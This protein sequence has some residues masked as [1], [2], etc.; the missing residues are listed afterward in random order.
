MNFPEA[1]CRSA[2]IW[3]AAERDTGT[4]YSADSF[5]VSF[6]RYAFRQHSL[7]SAPVQPASSGNS[8]D[9]P[10]LAT[11]IFQIAARSSGDGRSKKKVP[12]VNRRRSS[13][14]SVPIELHVA[15][16]RLRPFVTLPPELR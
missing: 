11:E 14:G 4:V 12:S 9:T 8:P 13:G 16:Q 3:S 10:Y 1:C 6:S 2:L 5:S 7:I 15:I